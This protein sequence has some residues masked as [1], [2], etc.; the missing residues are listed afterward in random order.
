MSLMN[1]L[2]PAGTAL[3][4]ALVGGA[5]TFGG[6][7][8][9]HRG[10]AR[11]EREAREHALVLR[12]YEVDQETLL[13]LQ[14]ALMNHQSKTVLLQ[15]KRLQRQ[16]G[17]DVGDLSDLTRECAE[18][19]RELK[20]LS[21]R[22]LDREVAAAVERHREAVRQALR[23]PVHEAE[24]EAAN[25]TLDAAQELIGKAIRQPLNEAL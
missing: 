19:V 11:R 25:E 4:G 8:F 22:V 12:R 1:D 21:A 6:Q 2:I 13:K 18:A 5:A 14:D 10:T 17:A 3:F 15:R 7:V 9:T 24:A 16:N 23:P 20:K